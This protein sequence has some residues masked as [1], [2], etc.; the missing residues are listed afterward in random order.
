VVVAVNLRL[1]QSDNFC[2]IQK[3]VTKVDLHHHLCVTLHCP[4]FIWRL[5]YMCVPLL[6][7]QEGC[8]HFRVTGW[9]CSPGPL[10]TASS[11]RQAV[12][13]RLLHA[14]YTFR[15]SL[16]WTDV[17]WH[18]R[19][20]TISV[21]NQFR[22]FTGPQQPRPLAWST[23]YITTHTNC[24]MLT[25]KN[26]KLSMQHCGCKPS[27]KSEKWN[28]VCGAQNGALQSKRMADK[29]LLIAPCQHIIIKTSAVYL[30]S[31]HQIISHTQVRWTEQEK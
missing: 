25:E 21:K 11:W 19:F 23:H 15:T 1:Q 28:T 2:K 9:V 24:V 22:Y 7:G 30:H 29:S 3:E 26:N 4:S 31:P 10:S 5:V 13:L 17:A 20:I 16:N 8:V 18:V 12:L 27:L 6:W 14:C